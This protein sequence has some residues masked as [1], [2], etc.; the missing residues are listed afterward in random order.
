MSWGGVIYDRTNGR[1]PEQKRRLLRGLATAMLR[2]AE[3]TRGMVRDW[4]EMMAA[5]EVTVLL[6][7]LL[8]G[9]TWD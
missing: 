1:S 5:A 8:K 3:R 7:C 2:S 6:G 4:T 9:E